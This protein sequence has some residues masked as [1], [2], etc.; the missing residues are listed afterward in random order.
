MAFRNGADP[1]SAVT[2]VEVR[3]VVTPAKRDGQSSKPT[4]NNSQAPA[5]RVEPVLLARIKDGGAQMRVEMR[6]ETVND[7]ATDMLDGAA[8]P[9]IVVF[10]DGKD[11]WLADGFHRVD[12]ARKINRETIDAEIREGTA[13]DAVLHG[14]GSNA[15]HGL[16]RSQADKRRAVERLLKDPEWARWSDRKI[17]EA[18][19]VD[20]KTVGT[21][22]KELSGEF[23][24]A[25][26][27]PNGKTS[28]EFPCG[29]PSNRASLL[30]DVL[31]AIPDDVL[32]AECRRRGLTVEAADV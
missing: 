14:I 3:K 21:I 15:A 26:G 19:K 8:F 11:F 9:P 24:T 29:K 25:H 7:Y 30:G 27:K 12:A 4:L 1:D 31:H 32:V 22:R 6:P 10:D 20:H 13:R 18:A 16:R 2:E 28:G 23:P 17:A 5:A